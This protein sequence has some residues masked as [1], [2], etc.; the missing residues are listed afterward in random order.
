MS[1][2]TIFHLYSPREIHYLVIESSGCG[3]K[4]ARLET[5]Q[6]DDLSALETDDLLLPVGLP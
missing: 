5:T 1:C 2:V 4:G 3:P 6:A